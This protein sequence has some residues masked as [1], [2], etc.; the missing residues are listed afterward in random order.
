MAQPAV[1]NTSSEKKAFNAA[2]EF[3][4]PSAS[5]L[6]ADGGLINASGHRQQLER[7]FGLMSVIAY[8]ITAGNTWIA[9]G[10]TIVSSL[11]YSAVF[12]TFYLSSETRGLTVKRDRRLQY[13]MV[14]DNARHWNS[15]AKH[16]P[17][18]V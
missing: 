13:T 12:T 3:A 8:A 15:L 4:S 7:N 1:G 6:S 9:L 16:H 14:G 17:N 2:V 5:S 18:A 11:T 10:G